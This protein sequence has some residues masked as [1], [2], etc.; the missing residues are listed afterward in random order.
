[1]GKEEEGEGERLEFC[2]E[3][4]KKKEKEK[5]PLLG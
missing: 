3:R 4:R 1:V 5:R 2:G